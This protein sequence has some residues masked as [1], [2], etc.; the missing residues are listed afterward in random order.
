VLAIIEGLNSFDNPDDASRDVKGIEWGGGLRA[1]L[2][3]DRMPVYTDY[4]DIKPRELL[5]YVER[6]DFGWNF[7]QSEPKPSS[8]GAGDES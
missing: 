1:V 2:G 8:S 4:I 7:T 6:G 5:G 3:P